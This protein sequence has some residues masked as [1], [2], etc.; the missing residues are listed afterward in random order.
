MLGGLFSRRNVE[1][2][3]PTVLRGQVALHEADHPQAVA[4]GGCF[5]VR[6]ARPLL[7]RALGLP[8][9][10]EGRRQGLLRFERGT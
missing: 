8:L 6:V 1:G 7:A 5:A 10:R 2:Q 9:G 3:R 4:P